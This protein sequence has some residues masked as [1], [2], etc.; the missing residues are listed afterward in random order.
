MATGA[1]V[2]TIIA[3][4]IILFIIID[5]SFY[6]NKKCGVLWTLQQKLAG[7]P[8]GDGD[9]ARNVEEGDKENKQP[10]LT[11]AK[12]EEVNEEEVPEKKNEGL[13]NGEMEEMSPDE[14]EAK[15]LAE[16]EEK[17]SPIKPDSPIVPQSEATIIVNP[18]T[19]ETESHDDKPV[20]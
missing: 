8:E 12:A 6:F 3:I 16:M 13:D 19:P 14:K 5:V 20:A 17:S 2:G 10:L 1:I 18:A 11:E 4:L 15:Q 7:K 9:G